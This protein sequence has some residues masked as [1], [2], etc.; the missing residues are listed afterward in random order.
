MQKSTLKHLSFDNFRIGKPHFIWESAS[1]DTLQVK[2]AGV[3]ANL[4][5]GTYKLQATVS[6]YQGGTV[7]ARCR[8]CNSEEENLQH[9]LLDCSSLTETREKFIA[10]I[11]QILEKLELAVFFKTNKCY[12]LQLVLDSTHPM[13]PLRVQNQE[14]GAL[15][16]ATTRSLC[17]ALHCKRS[18]LLDIPIVK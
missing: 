13:L 5:T 2:K 14:T 10:S 16:E 8:M 3:K 11:Y 18:A 9:F 7:S 17:C 6:K 1:L 15:L 4:L 12:F